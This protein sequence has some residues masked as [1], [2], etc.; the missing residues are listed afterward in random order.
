MKT[1]SKEKLAITKKFARDAYLAYAF[2][3]GADRNQYGKL[4][5]VLGNNFIQ[6]QDRYP[7]TVTAA[8]NLLLHW[9]QNPQNLMRA[10]GALGNSGIAFTNMEEEEGTTLANIGGKRDK[11]SITCFNCNERGHFSNKCNK[12]D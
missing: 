12:P 5:K 9:K 10:F 1:A 8:Y 4:I 11:S 3:L 6:G 7:K 2:L